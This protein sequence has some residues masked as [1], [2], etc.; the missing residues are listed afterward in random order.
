[1]RFNGHLAQRALWASKARYTLFAGGVGSGKTFAGACRVL[2]MPPSRGLVVAPTYALMRDGAQAVFFEL[3]PPSLVAEHNKAEQRTV[4]TTGVEILWRSADRPE[5]LTATNAGWAWGDEWS[6]VEEAAHLRL[7]AR[8]RRA[9]GLFWATTTPNGLNWLYRRAVS[10]G[11]AGWR[12]IHARTQD[13]AY[14]PASYIASLESEYEGAYAAQEL[15]GEFVDLSGTK[16]IPSTWLIRVKDFAPAIDAPGLPAFERLRVFEAPSP[17]RRYVL[18]VDP[19][20]GL[21]HGDAS[22]VQVID[23]ASGA[24]VAVLDAHMEP[25]AELPVAVQAL[26]EAYNRAPALVERNNHGHAVLAACKALGVPLL[27]GH[28][29]KAGWIAT[30]TSKARLWDRAAQCV[31]ERDC[32][33]TDEKTY[34]QV[35]AIDRQ[36]LAH[37]AKRKGLTACDDLAVSWAL[38]QMARLRPSALSWL[39]GR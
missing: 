31:K 3:C 16:R 32:V 2:Q 27:R 13:N 20:E 5:R 11:A 4:L 9:P 7:I 8:L 34:H 28:D 15:G 18:G 6:F 39:T 1:L 36:T 26:S 35:A 33:L 21:A 38:G 17:G 29:G 10:S 19:S 14:L 12:V 23:C 37:P 30:T 25:G 24:Q 22:P